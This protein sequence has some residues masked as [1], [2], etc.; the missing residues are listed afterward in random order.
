MLK[1][2]NDNAYVIDLPDS[3]GISNTFNVADLYEF[4]DDEALY[5]DHNLGSSSSEVEGTDVAQVAEMLN[6]QLK[7]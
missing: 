1:R 6:Q 2:I 7:N 5:R 3:M 4:R